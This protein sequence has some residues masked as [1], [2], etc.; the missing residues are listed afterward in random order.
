M[1]RFKRKTQQHWGI[2][3]RSLMGIAPEGL[4]LRSSKVLNFYRKVAFLYCTTVK[5]DISSH[6]NECDPFLE[7]N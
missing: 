5:Y 2:G 7:E 4:K 1:E 3:D 6:Y